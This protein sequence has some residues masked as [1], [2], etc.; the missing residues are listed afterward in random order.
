MTNS[1]FI[2]YLNT[3]HNVKAHN[4]SA[5]AEM[6]ISSPFYKQT[7]VNRP[8]GD[9]IQNEIVSHE[10]MIFILTG[11]A[12]DGKTAILLQALQS[13][14]ALPEGARLSE[15]ADVQLP[16]GRLCRCV[17]DFSE[18]ESEKRKAVFEEILCCPEQG[19]SA[20]LVANTGPLIATFSEIMGEVE[21][22]HLVGAID[23][24]TGIVEFYKGVPIE[25]LNVAT[26][27][28]ASFV[29]P[30]LDKILNAALWEKCKE[31]RKS[32]FCPIYT[33]YQLM[34]SEKEHVSDFIEKHYIWQQEYGNKLTVRQIVAHLVFSLTGGL[35][36]N[37]VKNQKG[38]RFKYLCSNRFFGYR[39]NRPDVG[40]A[41]VKAIADIMELGYDQKKLKADEELFIKRDLSAFNILA[42]QILEEDASDFQDR[43]G[44]NQAVRRMYILLNTETE[45]DK[46][47][48]QQL[49]KDIFSPC[50]PRF[51]EL[52]R[53]AKSS[54]WDKEL[55]YDALK[56]L[57]LGALDKEND[58]PITM[59]R[60]ENSF[61]SVQLVYD[62]LSKNSI[63]LTTEKNQ[64]FNQVERCQ[65]RIE[66][67]GHQLA[68][69]LTLPLM[70]HFDELRRGAIQTNID[71][72][73]SQ[74]IE[75]LRAQIIAFSQTTIDELQL[76]IMTQK[77]WESV[78]ASKD[79]DSWILQS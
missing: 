32:S 78:S 8:V 72:Q 12:G 23:K 14:G 39:G 22:N 40:A 38:I 19:R 24:N 65:V 25:V 51:L 11:H 70:N 73:L 18:L 68:T 16:C 55:V 41:S 75:S 37:Q 27:D 48:S 2:S 3:L 17:K 20:F 56:M 5:Y 30:Y 67:K 61:Q 50:F 43:T 9:Y 21:T 58:I 4:Q 62:T 47:K 64:D 34:S 46:E 31:C 29:R 36:C 49:E 69:M 33:N 35:N 63:K 53:G 76:R 28:N 59:N 57:F 44:W 60:G 10:P 1:D 79:N 13:W 45:K 71:P 7:M 26:V 77:G 52:R 42:R 74:G 54:Y 66:V 15:V 6:V